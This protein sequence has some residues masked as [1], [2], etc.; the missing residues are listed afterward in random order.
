M[1]I[2][3]AKL[4]CSTY[5][6]RFLHCILAIGEESAASIQQDGLIGKGLTCTKQLTS[7]VGC[8]PWIGRWPLL[9]C[10]NTRA[11]GGFECTVSYGLLQATCSTR[12][13]LSCCHRHLCTCS[14]TS[15]QGYKGSPAPAAL[16]E[17]PVSMFCWLALQ[18]LMLSSVA[19]SRSGKVTAVFKMPAAPQC[20]LRSLYQMPVQSAQTS[21]RCSACIM[22]D[23][24]P[25]H[26]DGIFHLT[27]LKHV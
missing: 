8:S 26:S 27:H 9:A 15:T 21:T 12:E 18:K 6:L 23:I 14:R 10:M 2:R 1:A 13:D 16:A 25:P 17:H 3:P 7:G 5:L 11:Q 4:P 19:V 22:G 24:S 20:L